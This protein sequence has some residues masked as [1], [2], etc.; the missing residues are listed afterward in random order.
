[1]KA[2]KDLTVLVTLLIIKIY[3]YLQAVGK[4]ALGITFSAILA[5]GEVT[6]SVCK[7]QEQT[8]KLFH[9]SVS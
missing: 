7:T 9:L 6:H 3:F 4:P 8:N 1:M 5:L 2:I